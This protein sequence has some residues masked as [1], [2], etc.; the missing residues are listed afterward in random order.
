[1]AIINWSVPFDDMF[2]NH[3]VYQ[4]LSDGK[5]ILFPWDLDQNFGEWKGANASIYMGEI[6][7]ADNRSGWAHYLKDAF[8]KS[9]R[10]EYDDRLLLL[11]NTILH[12]DNI[13]RLVDEVTAQSNPTEAAQAPAGIQCSFPGRAGTFKS[14]AVTRYGVV[15]GAIAKVKLDAGADQVVFAGST[16]QFDARASE[17][18]PGPTVAYTW[19]NGMEGD[20]PSAVLDA[21]GEHILTLTVTVRG[22][23]FKDEVAITV[24]P[25]PDLAFQESGGQVVMEAE[26]F[27]MNDR[28]NAANTWWEADA[29]VAGFSGVNY[30]EA[31]QTRRQTFPSRYARLAPEL[32][33]AVVFQNTGTY[34]VWVRGYSKDTFADSCYVGLDGQERPAGLAQ[35][36]A[37][38]PAAFQWSGT[39]RTQ[40]AQ[41][42]TVEKPG[43][44]L[45]SI[46]VRDSAQIVDKV[47]L[48]QDLVTAPVD[49]GPP[50]SG[51]APVSGNRP[52]VRGDADGSTTLS[53]SDAL[54]V[55]LHL[56]GG[57]PIDCQDH[58][59]ADDNGRLDVTDPVVILDFLFRRGLPPPAPFPAPGFD[60]TP[61][62]E[63]CG[64]G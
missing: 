30:M 54:G 42:L 36:F 5:W 9:F 2:Q 46:W 53:V 19:S 24:L 7:N 50:E 61:D 27:F 8:L 59:D 47:I 12:P 26:S 6:G 43:L 56:F 38:D 39:T 64:D 4:R 3:F 57:V 17:P 29:T 32:G 52:F 18:D 62:G 40:V 60:P 51:K 14:F 33:Y 10:T 49:L 28:H 45:F 55:L 48:T 16:V 41:T 21:P 20:F 11:N 31:K 63:D 22:I 13:A 23:D 34:R 15:N 37:A 44:H 25:V 35:L 58:G 1:M